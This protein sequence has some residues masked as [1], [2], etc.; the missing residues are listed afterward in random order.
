[1]AVD[2]GTVRMPRQETLLPKLFSML[3]KGGVLAVQVPCTQ[4]M[5]IHTELEKLISTDAWKN[6]FADMTSAYSTHTVDFYY[7]IL[8][9]L[10]AEI[11]LWETQYFHIMNSHADIVKWYSGSG[12]R[13]YLDC[14]QD[15]SAQAEFIQEY[16]SALENVYPLQPDGRILFPFTRIFFIAKNI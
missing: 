8:C 6:R 9:G 14:L 16:E 3:S 13:P 12:L 11:D 1:M 7:R 4:D 10:T 15:S 2:R 5:P